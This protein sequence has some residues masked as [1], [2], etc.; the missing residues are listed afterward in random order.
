MMSTGLY[1][2]TLSISAICSL[3][4]IIRSISESQNKKPKYRKNRTHLEKCQQSGKK[5]VDFSLL[6]YKI[7][8]STNI[9]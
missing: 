8:N 1:I 5:R 2:C 6:Y 4:I 9:F 7:P 3:I